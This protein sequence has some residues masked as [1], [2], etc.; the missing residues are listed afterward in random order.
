MGHMDQVVDEG[1]K[2]VQ[3]RQTDQ[4]ARSL[5][6]RVEGRPIGGGLKGGHRGGGLYRGGLYRGGLYRGGLYRGG[7]QGRSR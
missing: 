5:E 3:E 4:R 1:A 2:A 7:L 6:G